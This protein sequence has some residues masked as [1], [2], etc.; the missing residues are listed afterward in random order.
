MAVQVVVLEQVL[1]LLLKLPLRFNKEAAKAHMLCLVVT[2][3]P[4]EEGVVV[5]EK[6]T[7]FRGAFDVLNRPVQVQYFENKVPIFWRHLV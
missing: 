6:T 5:D 3:E 7:I 4:A 2:V 1:L